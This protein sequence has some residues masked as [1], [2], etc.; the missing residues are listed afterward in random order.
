M[1]KMLEKLILLRNPNIHPS[2]SG[3]LT[4]PD[5]RFGSVG[6]PKTPCLAAP[7]PV[8]GRRLLYTIGNL[9]DNVQT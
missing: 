7:R 8:P 6:S 9:C 4:P 5:G 2:A 1:L 3:L